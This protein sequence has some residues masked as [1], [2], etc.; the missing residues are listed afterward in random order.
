MT[1]KNQFLNLKHQKT[2]KTNILNQ[3]RIQI[4]INPNLLFF[5]KI[6]STKNFNE[7]PRQIEFIGAKNYLFCL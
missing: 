6:N 1:L 5:C 2:S 7:I 4:F 3:V